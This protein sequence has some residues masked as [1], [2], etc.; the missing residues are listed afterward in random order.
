MNDR[1]ASA[2][3]VSTGYHSAPN[4]RLSADDGIEYAYRDVG[5]RGGRALVLLQHL[6][7]NLDN[8][9]IQPWWTRLRSTV[10]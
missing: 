2:G 5:Q 8:W 6:R 4:L 10:G 3:A 7:G 9:G 1:D